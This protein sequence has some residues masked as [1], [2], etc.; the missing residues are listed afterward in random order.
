M[1]FLC[2]SATGGNEAGI[3]HELFGG[4]DIDIRIVKE[5]ESEFVAQD[6]PHRLV[7]P[8]LTKPS[9]FDQCNNHLGAGLAAQDVT[10]RFDNA[11]HP[12]R[13]AQMLDAPT[14]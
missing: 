6:A 11:L 10:P 13:H 14:P 3:A 5:T 9:A 2:A 7:N 12:L 8:R 4:S 1:D